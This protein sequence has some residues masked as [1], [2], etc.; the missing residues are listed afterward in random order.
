MDAWSGF[1]HLLWSCFAVLHHKI[2]AKCCSITQTKWPKQLWVSE[3]KSTDQR[4][5]GMKPTRAQQTQLQQQQGKLTFLIPLYLLF[6]SKGARSVIELKNPDIMSQ[7]LIGQVIEVGLFLS[8]SFVNNQN[9]IIFC[10]IWIN[11]QQ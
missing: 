6:R 1:E 4:G 8:L 9:C 10:V 7:R 5:V 11:V 3:T 2:R